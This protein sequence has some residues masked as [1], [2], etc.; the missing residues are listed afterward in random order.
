MCQCAS[1]ADADWNLHPL[2]LHCCSGIS[3][4]WLQHRRHQR[5][6][7]GAKSKCFFSVHLVMHLS[8]FPETVTVGNRW[9]RGILILNYLLL[10]FF[11][12][13]C[14]KAHL[15]SGLQFA[16]NC[17]KLHLKSTKM[18]QAE[19]RCLI[20]DYLISLLYDVVTRT[21]FWKHF[22]VTVR[23]TIPDTWPCNV[24]SCERVSCKTLHVCS[25]G[26][27]GVF[28]SCL[29]VKWAWDRAAAQQ[30][31]S[32]GRPSTVERHHWRKSHLRFAAAAA[33]RGYSAEM[34]HTSLRLI[35]SQCVCGTTHWHN[36]GQWFVTNVF[37]RRV[38]VPS[39]SWASTISS[40]LQTAS[41]LSLSKHEEALT[42]HD[43]FIYF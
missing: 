22:P 26:N 41:F 24:V 1:P 39:A 28:L 18:F 37:P 11:W 36:V 43:L 31:S 10:K 5:T 3:A 12:L 42:K 9:I 34:S 15:S 23:E 8:L 13:K 38:T 29:W 14:F 20:R 7:K 21:A 30:G 33:R 27:K 19:E 4:V 17:S 2:S 40:W 16:R 6:A 25:D 35:G 32:I